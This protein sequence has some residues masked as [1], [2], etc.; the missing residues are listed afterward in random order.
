VV[1]TASGLVSYIS[2]GISTVVNA[3]K[4]TFKSAQ[5]AYSSIISNAQINH[6]TNML[7]S[8]E[9]S[10]QEIKTCED[11]I[12]ELKRLQTTGAS[13]KEANAVYAS[14]CSDLSLLATD[15]LAEFGFEAREIRLMHELMDRIDAVYADKST[16]ERDAIY[17]KLIGSMTYNSNAWQLTIGS[18]V[19]NTEDI[20]INVL[21][22]SAED[23]DFL[24]YKVRVQNQI[25]G[26]RYSEM[27]YDDQDPPYLSD[28]KKIYEEVTGDKISDDQ[29]RVYW[30]NQYSSMSGK[31]DFAHLSIIMATYLYS[32]YKDLSIVGK[33]VSALVAIEKGGSD[34]LHELA[35]WL[36]DSTIPAGKMRLPVF[37][38]DD[39]IADLDSLNIYVKMR[40]NPEITY[41]E[42]FHEYY[43]SLANGENRVEMF[44]QHTSMEHIKY[45]IQSRL[46]FEYNAYSYTKHEIE[47]YDYIDMEKLRSV[48]PDTYNFIRSLE[49][50][51]NTM[52]DYATFDNS[53]DN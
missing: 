21:G 43:T 25:A 48:A 17:T 42:A 9:L 8:R 49:E 32:D 11:T 34:K 16:R 10:A 13:L 30:K 33:I 24:R 6:F 41:S 52:I 46:D 38:G 26:D 22:M 28:Y 1:K 29:F 7:A 4:T 37:G 50:K 47:D 44:L 19:T 35:G 53:L 12:V 51:D 5:Q 2:N 14:A 27:I 36:G 39:Y 31:G 3:V 20:I 15:T 18:V 45:E 23:Y 40:D